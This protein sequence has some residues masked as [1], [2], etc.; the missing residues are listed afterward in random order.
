MGLIDTDE[1]PDILATGFGPVLPNITFSLRR[2]SSGTWKAQV[3]DQSVFFCSDATL[4]DVSGDGFLDA[5]LSHAFGAALSWHEN[6]GSGVFLP[7]QVPQSP[8]TQGGAVVCIDLDG[9]SDL[10]ALVA[11]APRPYNSAPLW[12]AENDG[13]APLASL[14][15]FANTPPIISQM[16]RHLAAGDIAG[17]PQPDL[18]VVQNGSPDQ[19]PADRILLLLDPSI[20]GAQ[21]QIELWRE[22]AGLPAGSVDAITTADWDGDG[23]ADILFA[24]PPSQ[25]LFWMRNLGGG[26]FKSAKLVLTT[27]AFVRSISVGDLNANAVPDLTIA[28]HD[29]VQWIERGSTP[30]APTSTILLATNIHDLLLSDMDNDGDAD[31]L[32]AAESGLYLLSNAA[33]PLDCDGSGIPDYIEIAAGNL[34]DCNSNWTADSCEIGLQ[35]GLDL[36]GD[37]VLDECNP[38]PLRARTVQASLI[39]GGIQTLW[40]DAGTARSSNAFAL[41][42]SASGTAPGVTDSPSGISVPLNIDPYFNLLLLNAGAG[43]VAP[44][45]GVLDS[46]GAATAVVTV[47]S[48]T[49][50]SFVGLTLHHAYITI[51]LFDTGLMTFASNAVPLTLTP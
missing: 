9:D 37:G 34:P 11:T 22:E 14:A 4:A 24:H 21:T 36:N 43:I 31:V 16:P 29:S 5:V 50:M 27:S 42:G 32:V 12:V 47:P 46:S 40:L 13:S 2:N 41:L 7:R 45:F 30:S 51:D 38:P 26:N 33:P 10:D 20:T 3:L 8:P 6:D 48:G 39:D 44:L 25:A 49:D 18:I 1:L 28:T 15:P 23:L 35:A 17:G 19:E